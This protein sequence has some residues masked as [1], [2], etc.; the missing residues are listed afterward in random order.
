MKSHS[1]QSGPMSLSSWMQLLTLGAVWG[2]S[3]FFA[4][5][6]VMEIPPLTLVLFRVGIAAIALHIYLA[7]RGISFKPVLDRAGSFF[8]LAALNNVIPFSLIFIGQTELGAGLAAILNATTPFWTMLVANRLTTDE[9]LTANKV[10]GI[11]IGVTGTA[12]MIG[13]GMLNELGGATWP[14][15]AIIGAAISYAFAATYAKRFRNMV[16]TQI[17]AGQLTASTF[18][19]VPLVVAI[20]GTAT[21]FSAS[22]SIWAAVFA[23]ALVSTAWAYILF[24]TLIANAGATNTTLVTLIVPMSAMLLGSLFL[25]ETL[26][27]FEIA[28]MTLIGTGLLI[29]DGRIIRFLH[30]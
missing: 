24:F 9:R 30:R 2:A 15:L 26:Q 5:V 8:V 12:I 28:G 7:A 6:A 14:K 11:L 29:I 21:M 23:L 22:P 20:D 10:A 16:T 18:I 19:M 27:T 3:F 1:P 13:P 4:R 17:A 25:S